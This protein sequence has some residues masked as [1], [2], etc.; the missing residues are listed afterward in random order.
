MCMSI[1]IYI[2]GNPPRLQDPDAFTDATVVLAATLPLFFITGKEGG[3]ILQWSKM[4]GA[5][6]FYGFM[7]FRGLG[8]GVG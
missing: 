3:T 8:F 1:Y 2:D 5:M 4:L 6:G 7:G